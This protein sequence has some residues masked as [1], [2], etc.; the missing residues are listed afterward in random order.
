MWP[1]FWWYVELEL[2]VYKDFWHTYYWDRRQVFLFSFHTYLVLLLYLRKLSRPRYQ[3]KLNKIMNISQEDMILIKKSLSVKAVWCTESIEWI[4]R[5]ELETWKH[6]QSA[7]EN[8]KDGY[9]IVRQTGS[10][11]PSSARSSEGPCAQS[12]GEARKAS[13]N[14]LD[15]A[16]NCHSL[17][18]CTQENNSPWPPAHMLQTMS[19]SAVV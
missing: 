9:N 4:A 18:K 19:C 2:S 7:K 17:F 14:S 13:V 8:P 10:G 5:Q 3:P 12:G 15:F 1:H 16:W 11:R 6:R